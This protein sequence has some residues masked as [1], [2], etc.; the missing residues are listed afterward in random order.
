MAVSSPQEEEGCALLTFQ[1]QEKVTEEQRDQIA[2]V[3]R[4]RINHR[5]L[6]EP[7]FRIAQDVIEI[8]IPCVRRKDLEEYRTLLTKEASLEL[9]PVASKASHEEW[10]AASGTK[11]GKWKENA[12]KGTEAVENNEKMSGEFEYLGFDFILVSKTPVVTGADV[13][14]ASAS[15]ALAESGWR[16]DFE[17]S[18]EGAKRFDAAAKELYEQR[19]LLAILLDG[20]IQSKP[21]I[22]SDKFGGRGQITGRFTKLEAENLAVLLRSGPLPA[23]IRL[24]NEVFI[25]HGAKKS[26]FE[27]PKTREGKDGWEE[28]ETPI[29]L[30]PATAKDLAPVQD[31]MEAAVVHF[32]AALL[33]KD[34]RYQEVLPKERSDRLKRKMAEIE[35]WAFKEV[36]LLGVKRKKEGKCTFR[37]FLKIEVNGKAD[38]G[39]DSGEAE[40][41]DGKWCVTSPPT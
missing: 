31:S 1:I 6:R 22:M 34:K 32:Y 13:K 21:R 8:Q 9:R 18:E 14:N 39:R 10:L 20:R 2:N 29:V 36:R 3:L 17:L 7:W 40:R 24:V 28:Y 5:G 27:I 35:T 37:V 16:V 25:S 38:E 30:T 15:P 4:R 23:G 19:G 33:R 41:I 11:E 12:P 26:G